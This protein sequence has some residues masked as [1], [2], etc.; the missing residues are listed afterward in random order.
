MDN[1]V[2]TYGLHVSIFYY[3][4]LHILRQIYGISTELYE[5]VS[6]VFLPRVSFV[7][8]LHPL[9]LY[10]SYSSQ[11]TTMMA[12][13]GELYYYPFAYFSMSKNWKWNQ[14]SVYI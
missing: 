1:A 10:Y 2:E 3:R 13:L 8:L 6:L 12:H 7:S 5:I 9:R 4:L 14:N 11:V